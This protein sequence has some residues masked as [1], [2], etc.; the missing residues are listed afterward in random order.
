MPKGGP[1]SRIGCQKGTKVRVRMPKEGSKSK[2][3]RCQKESKSKDKMP[4]GGGQNQRIRCQK[5]RD[6]I[7]GSNRQVQRWQ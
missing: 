6:R 5:S 3:K 1:K 4:K 7:R 2:D